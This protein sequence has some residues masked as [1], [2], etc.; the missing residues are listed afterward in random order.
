MARRSF[1]SI[2]GDLDLMHHL[3]GYEE[4]IRPWSPNI[5]FEKAAPLELEIGSGKGLFLRKAAME[6]P[7]H[8]FMGIEVSLRYAMI[9]AAKL[10]KAGL[11]N[12]ISVNAD[13]AKV[14]GELVPRDSLEAVHVYFPDPWWKKSHRKRRILRVEV[15]QMI[16]FTVRPG[17]KLH[18]WTDVQEY[19]ESTLE[20]IAQHTTLEGPF[21]VEVEDDP[22]VENEIENDSAD[23]EKL[24]PDC[25]HTH[26]ERRTRLNHK[27]VYRSFFIVKEN[28]NEGAV[29]NE[30][31]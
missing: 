17:G 14:L 30:R 25:F 24:N 28:K 27:P 6:Q 8:N 9:T 16:E 20:L 29:Q 21:P 3:K 5:Y 22:I 31:D 19:Y 7:D 1:A 23:L 15:L 18:F 12:A 26:F 10:C 2:R 11:K 4:L 13:A